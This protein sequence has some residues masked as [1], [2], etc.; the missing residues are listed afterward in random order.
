MQER[1]SWDPI[2]HHVYLVY[3]GSSNSRGIHAQ[4]QIIIRDPKRFDARG[5][6]GDHH[7]DKAIVD[8]CW[9]ISFCIRGM[10]SSSH[11]GMASRDIHKSSSESFWD[12][13]ISS[14]FLF[15]CITSRSNR[16]IW[17]NENKCHMTCNVAIQSEH[18]FLWSS[19]TRTDCRLFAL[20]DDPAWCQKQ[21]IQTSAWSLTNARFCFAGI[22]S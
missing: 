4:E 8:F 16:W 18:S 10:V 9:W 5:K 21:A 2:N 22:R 13:S 11:M 1:N 20:N 6:V 12:G 15:S 14:I 17:W 7:L 19:D 3:F